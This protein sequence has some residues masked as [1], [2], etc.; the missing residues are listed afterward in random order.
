MQTKI[1]R[2]LRIAKQNATDEEL[3]ELARNPEAAQKV[4]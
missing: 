3:E 2:Q 1:K 4:F